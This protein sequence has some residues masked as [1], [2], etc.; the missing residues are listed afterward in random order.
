MGG[1]PYEGKLPLVTPVSRQIDPLLSL[2]SIHVAIRA[3]DGNE[4]PSLLD[5]LTVRGIQPTLRL[6]F[7]LCRESHR[8]GGDLLGGKIPV[9]IP[10]EVFQHLASLDELGCAH[11]IRMRKSL[12]IQ[13][14]FRPP[15]TGE[16]LQ[17]RSTLLAAA[18]APRS[19][20]SVIS[21]ARRTV[22][23]EEFGPLG[24]GVVAQQGNRSFGRN[25]R[26]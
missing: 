3:L 2:A 15:P 4:F 19:I 12:R 16:A 21:V 5:K 25:S 23:G 7:C 20:M 26:R 18:R 11:V 14:A 9:G 22:L 8:H 24:E 1:I 6:E 10:L 13:D 17:I